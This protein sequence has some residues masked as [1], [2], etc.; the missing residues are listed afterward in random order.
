MHPLRRTDTTRL[1]AL[2]GISFD[3]RKGEMMGIVGRN[4]SGKTTLLKLLASIYRAD[5]GTIRVAGTLAPFIELGV[6]F[7]PSLTAR[8]NVLLNGVMMGLTPARGTAPLRRGD[9]VRRARGLRRAE[10]QELLVRD[11]D[12]PGVLGHGPGRRRG[13]AGRRG[14][15]G[16]RRLVRPEVQ[17]RLRAHA[18]R[19][20]DDPVRHTR[21]G[22]HALHVRRGDPD[23][24]RA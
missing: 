16:R 2:R 6:G 24:R 3:V 1:E 4:G 7:N 21:H 10:A 8:D 14:P 9:R 5:S 20:P 19:G 13:D 11:G 12:A 15:G 23:P 17:R 22:E 18:R